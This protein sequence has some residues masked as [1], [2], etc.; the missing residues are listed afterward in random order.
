MGSAIT[1]VYENCH[2]MGDNRSAMNKAKV[3]ALRVAAT[4]A[5]ARGEASLEQT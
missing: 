4:I 3:S 2:I 1:V 5:R